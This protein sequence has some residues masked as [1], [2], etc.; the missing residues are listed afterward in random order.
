MEPTRGSAEARLLTNFSMGPVVK[1]NFTRMALLFS[2]NHGC[3]TAVLNLSV[4]LLGDAGAY[5]N[6][7]LYVAY[8]A[9]A[10]LAAPA[11]VGYLGQRGA[12]ITGLWVYCV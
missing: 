10:L 8:A 7:S 12:L 2:I 11:I 6:A 1:R 5:M 4:V 9:T 3:V